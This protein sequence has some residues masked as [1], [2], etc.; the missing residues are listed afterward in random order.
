MNIHS[1]ARTCPASRALLVERVEELGWTVNEAADAAGVSERT[2]YKWLARF[3]CEGP[4][5]LQDRSSRPHRS[6]RQTSAA[7]E[8]RV[9]SLRRK[10]YS[11][12]LVARK[13][14]MPRST[15]ACVF[16]RHGLGQLRRLDPKEP[17]HRYE[18][19]EPGDLLHVD[20]KRLA[21]IERPGHRVH[22]DR[23][24]TVKGAGHEAVHVAVDDHSRVAF[25]A[26][27]PDQTGE[28]AVVFLKWALAF[29]AT[30]GL[31][32]RRVL[33]DNGSAYE[34]QLWADACDECGLEHWRTRPFRPQTNG[35][36]ER[37]IQTLLREWA[38]ARPYAHSR[39]RTRALRRYLEHYNFERPHG[40]LH[41][42]PPGSRIP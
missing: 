24:T 3:R 39:Y 25:S 7:V 19:D 16:N 4:V 12:P 22:G 40:S 41:D 37:F 9:L 27:L 29:Y 35:K 42:E 36:A 17:V 1:C 2:T 15:V 38:Y 23:R 10:R 18:W 6:P 21:R 5:G 11:G 32:L 26:V 13:M 20:I 8:R 33:T 31:T 28:S 34:S 14:S 30:L